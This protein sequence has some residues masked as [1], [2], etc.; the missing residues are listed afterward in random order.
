MSDECPTWEVQAMALE[1]YARRATVGRRD[2]VIR[3]RLP[4][5][6]YERFRDHCTRLGL[7]I[8]EAVFLLIRDEVDRPGPGGGRKDYMEGPERR[9]EGHTVATPRPQAIRTRRSRRFVVAPYVVDGMV[10]CPECKTWV[11]RSNISRHMRDLHDSDT[12]TVYKAN[13]ETVEAMVKEAR[14]DGPGE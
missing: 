10:P 5:D 6:L 2:K 7:T 12:E 14:A 1:R 4:G 13:L 11:S 8:S 9:T 3:A